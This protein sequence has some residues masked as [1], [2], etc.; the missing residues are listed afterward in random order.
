MGEKLVEMDK[1]MSAEEHI[2]LKQVLHF[3]F[4]DEMMSKF[5]CSQDVEL[6]NHMFNDAD[7]DGS[8]DI[9]WMEWPALDAN[10]MEFDV[11]FYAKQAS[12]RAEAQKRRQDMLDAKRATEERSAE[13][14]PS[15]DAQREPEKQN[16]ALAAAIATQAKAVAAASEV[17]TVM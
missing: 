15:T 6:V 9:D 13:L 1:E 4:T 11:G 7:K 14:E 8:G 3:Y 2:S 12:Q 16:S 10:L 17:P 5:D